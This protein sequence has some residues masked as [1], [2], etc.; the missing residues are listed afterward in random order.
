MREM[1]RTI[2]LTTHYLAEA[3][4]L[5]ERIVVIDRGRVIAEGSPSE[6]KGRATGRTIRFHSSA[7]QE[8]I[9]MLRPGLT[10]R[11]NGDLYEILTDAAEDVTRQLLTELGDMT[12]LEITSAGL[13]DAF[14]ALTNHEEERVA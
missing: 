3:D 2:L 5:A 6:I 1:G 7:T 12:A 8:R 10:V 14:M 11:R 4:A 13:E 9:R